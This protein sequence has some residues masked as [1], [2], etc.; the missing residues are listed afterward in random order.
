MG[1][2]ERFASTSNDAY[3]IFGEFVVSPSE[4]KKLRS[5]VDATV[6]EFMKLFNHKGKFEG[7]RPIRDDG[8][9]ARNGDFGKFWAGF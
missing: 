3:K 8:V 1:S 7:S 4:R 2:A 5:N 6:K 9:C